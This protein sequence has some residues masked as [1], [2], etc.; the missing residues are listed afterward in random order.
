MRTLNF[1]LE[2]KPNSLKNWKSLLLLVF[3]E[4]VIFMM[5][6][7]P[8]PCAVKSDT[9]VLFTRTKSMYK[10]QVVREKKYVIYLKKNSS[11]LIFHT[12]DNIISYFFKSHFLFLTY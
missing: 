5:S 11:F 1:Y 7:F 3:S 8:S 2:S 9:Y 12:F 6:R 10:L 4:V